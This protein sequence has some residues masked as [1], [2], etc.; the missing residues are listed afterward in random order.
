M[1]TKWKVIGGVLGVLIVAVAAAES[2][3]ALAGDRTPAAI[4]ETAIESKAQYAYRWTNGFL[5]RRF[6]TVFTDVIDQG[7]TKGMYEG[8]HIEL[9]NG[10]GAWQ[11]H[12]YECLVDLKAERILLVHV[13]PGRLP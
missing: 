11:P 2:A 13:E 4:C 8:D 9:Q 7:V 6:D 5:E 3:R 1:K 12:V 10:F